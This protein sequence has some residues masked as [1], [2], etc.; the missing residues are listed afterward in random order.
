[1][2]LCLAAG[3]A[4]AQ[5]TLNPAQPITHQLLVQPIIARQAASEG[6]A[7]AT[8]FGGV[9]LEIESQVDA[10]WAQAGIDVTFLDPIYY[11]SSFAYNGYPADYSSTMRPE[12][13]MSPMFTTG[14]IH[15]DPTVLNMFFL[16]VVPGYTKNGI[17][18]VNGLSYLDRNGVAVYVGENLLTWPQGI[19]AVSTVV[20]HEIGHSLGLDHIVEGQNLMEVG[21][22]GQRIS[23]A[24]VA[25]IFTDDI[26]IDGYDLLVAVPEPSAGFLTFATLGIFLARRR[27]L[28]TS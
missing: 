18:T 17:N 7:T 19:E 13:D 12:S 8:Y 20:S 24:Q 15:A 14:P 22:T 5:L 26:G 25:T 21:H 6:G 28:K 10:I 4:G 2:A 9:A 16:D 27:R 23:S 1:M 3:E 11:E